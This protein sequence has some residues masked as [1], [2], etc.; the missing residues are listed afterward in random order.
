MDVKLDTR[1][2]VIYLCLVLR[3]Y[4]ENKKENLHSQNLTTA[5]IFEKKAQ[6]K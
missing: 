5:L 3:N 2:Q 4:C 6:S 1:T